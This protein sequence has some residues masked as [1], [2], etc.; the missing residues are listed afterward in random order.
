MSVLERVDSLWRYPVKSMR[1]EEIEQGFAGFGGIYG[2]RL[3]AWQSAARP[4]EFPWLTARIT[5]DPDTGASSPALLR[6][7]AQAHEG[8]A[9][10]YG[11]V[12]VEGLLR[13]GDAVELLD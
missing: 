6:Q 12:L 13:K 9:G 1:G 2:D 10:V 11:A 7:V 4:K 5:L 8:T 3:F